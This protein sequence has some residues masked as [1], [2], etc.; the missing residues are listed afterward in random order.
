MLSSRETYQPSGRV[1]WGRLALGLVLSLP[2]PLLA[3]FVLYAA[4]RGG[5]YVVF[6][7]PLFAA[8]LAGGAAWLTI[9][10]GKCRNRWV[11]AAVGLFVGLVGLVSSYQFDLVSEAGLGN[12]HRLDLL[13]GHVLHRVETDQLGKLLR[14]PPA[15]GPLAAAAGRPS[16]RVFAWGMLLFE[17]VCVGLFPAYL[18]WV[19]A[20]RPFSEEEGRWLH[21]YIFAVEP[22]DAREMAEALN[23]GDAAALAEVAQSIPLQ[24]VSRRGEVRLYYLPNKPDTSVYLTLRIVDTRPWSHGWPQKLATRVRLG[25]DEALALA[26]QLRIPGASFGALDVLPVPERRRAAPA[27]V[28]EDLP[29]D[30]AAKVLN[31]R[32]IAAL[33][34]IALLPLELA[35]LIAIGLGVAVSLYWSDLGGGVKLGAAVAALT[36]IVIGCVLAVRYGD[37]LVARIRQRLL[38][39]AIRQRPGALVQ[40]DDPDAVH[41]GIVPRENWGRVKLEDSSDIGLLKIDPGRREL[42]FEGVRQRWR[43]PGD[44]IES[45]ALEEYTIGPPNANRNNVFLIAVLRVTRD[46][47]IW[48]APLRPMQD[49]LLSP[50]AEA[51]RQRCRELRQRIREEL[52]GSPA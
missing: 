41:V 7:I 34:A 3:G 48:E 29:P 31:G 51:K 20:S 26:E 13:P 45:C 11:G 32:F 39:A 46:G 42:L 33:L 25:A 9:S 37:G 18:G 40:P 15:P 27:A 50:T 19:R 36:G 14:T 6:L 4:F 38:A 22:E 21:E 49:T 1:H 23:E 24:A 8:L 44:S 17:G 16:R 28:I 47:S 5:F 43:I 52:L 30:D 10:A 2:L 35:L 12:L